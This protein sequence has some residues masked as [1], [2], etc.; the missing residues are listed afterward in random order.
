MAPFLLTDVNPVKMPVAIVA[1]VY[2]K[3]G[4]RI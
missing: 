2:Y 3:S 4:A 1:M